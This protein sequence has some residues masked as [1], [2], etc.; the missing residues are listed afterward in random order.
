MSAGIIDHRNVGARISAKTLIATAIL[1]VIG[2]S[3]ICSNVLLEMRRGDE[4]LARQTSANLASTIDADI[5][6]NLELY[7]LS[8]R[9]VVEG[10]QQPAVEQMSPAVRQLILFDRAATARHF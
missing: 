3:A 4:A 5:G 1:T 9:A 6:R 7:D 8:L 2:F 10:M